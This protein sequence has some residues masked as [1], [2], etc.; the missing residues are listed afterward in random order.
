[1]NEKKYSDFNVH[2]EKAKDLLI[3][4]KTNSEKCTEEV[5]KIMEKYNCYFSVVTAIVDGDV[6]SQ[7]FIK[8]RINKEGDKNGNKR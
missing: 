7:T 6:E 1:M 8:E 2:G 3:G 5:N 4:Q